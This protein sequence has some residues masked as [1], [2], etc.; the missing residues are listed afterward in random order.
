MAT[1]KDMQ[2]N[3]EVKSAL[4]IVDWDTD[5]EGILIPIKGFSGIQ[6]GVLQ[7]LED[8]SLAAS[9]TLTVTVHSVLND[10]EAPVAGNQIAAFTVVTGSNTTA[11][12]KQEQ[13]AINLDL[14]D[15]DKPY[16]QFDFVEANTYDGL[17]SAFVVMGGATALP[18][19]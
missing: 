11:A 14:C 15:V 3:A 5:V 19:N 18:L 10:A 9:N 6:K 8:G 7:I 13:I 1:G 4:A 12:Q 16:I 2:S 17:V